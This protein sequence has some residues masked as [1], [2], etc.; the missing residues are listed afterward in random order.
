MKTGYCISKLY[1]SNTLQN[2]TIT[3]NYSDFQDVRLP[4]QQNVDN[5]DVQQLYK[6]PVI[7]QVVCKW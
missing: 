6:V 3:L 2:R 7:N 4:R 1:L 5:C